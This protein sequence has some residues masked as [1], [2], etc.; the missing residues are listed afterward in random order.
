MPLDD[1]GAQVCAIKQREARPARPNGADWREKRAGCA[2][3]RNLHGG[4]FLLDPGRGGEIEV[5]SGD[6]PPVLGRASQAGPTPPPGPE[7]ILSASAG[8]QWPQ[9]TPLLQTERQFLLK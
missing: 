9:R 8:Q 7:P 1:G 5:G 3:D 2:G 4:A 6:A